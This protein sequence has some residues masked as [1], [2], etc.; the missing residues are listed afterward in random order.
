[1][2]KIH[3]EGHLYIM[4]ALIFTI[5]VPAVFGYLGLATLV[6]VSR[7]VM[8]L[9]LGLVV[10][11]FRIPNRTLTF[12]AN[13]LIAPADGKV[14]VIEEVFEPEFLKTQCRQISIFMNPVDVHHNL[15][16]AEGTVTYFK[17]HPG[18]YL[19][20]WLPKSSTENERTTLAFKAKNG[21]TVVMRQIAGALARRIMTYPKEGQFLQQNEEFG[22]IKFG[23]RVDVYLPLTCKVLVS[24]E[25][26]TTSGITPIAEWTT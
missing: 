13:Q 17:Y 6:W 16:P 12:N 3:R 14:V 11:F 5:A 4:G 22:F 9:I 10:N 19:A 8:V 7:L 21:E 25:Q 23:S 1:M 20:A 18:K 15:M 26:R 24:L 2:F